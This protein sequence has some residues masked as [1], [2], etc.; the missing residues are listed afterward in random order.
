MRRLFPRSLFGQTLLVLLAGLIASQLAGWWIYS[1]DR[2]QAVRAVGG[3]AAAQRITNLTQLVQEAP[4]EW[5]ARLV[6]G[7]SDQSIQVSLSS[8]RPAIASSSEDS[9]AAQVITAFLAE[10]LPAGS[11]EQPLVSVS[12]PDGPPFGG[13][14]RMGPGATMHGFGGFAGFGPFRD[15]Q[16]AVP[17]SDGQWLSFATALPESGPAVSRQFLFSMGIMAFIILAVSV[18]A[19]RR[20]TAPLASL[21]A[22]AERLGNDLNA[23]PIPESGTIETRRSSRTFN[24]MQARLRSLIE[25]RTRMLAAISHDLRTPLQL[26]RLRVETVE[27]VSERERMLATIAEM[28]S[29]LGATL[30]L[31]RDEAKTELRRPTDIAALVQSVVDD[32]ADAGLDVAMEPAQPVVLEGRPDALRRALRNLIDNAVKH[33]NAA[34]VAIDVQ[35]DAVEISI[36]DQGPGIPEEELE[37][38]FQPFYRVEASRNPET[39]G[40]GLGLAIALS[41]IQAHGGELKLV[42]RTAGGLRASVTLPR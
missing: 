20:V 12:A 28:D 40:I 24:A 31:A 37:R 29:M 35:S 21:S 5:R 32:M 17:L 9:I 38:V 2:E 41:I 7:L 10:Q 18:W 30:Q 26:L 22:A 36:D 25:N 15:L 39:G 13:A 6:A 23:P 19:V 3:L 33:G 27:N 8:R 42:N 14:H 34:K 1:S 4:P 11:G 16:V